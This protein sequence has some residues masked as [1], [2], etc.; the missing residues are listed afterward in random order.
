MARALALATVC[1]LAAGLSSAAAQGLF[2]APPANAPAD[3]AAPATPPAASQPTDSAAA[4]PVQPGS[5][6]AVGKPFY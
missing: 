2:G 1:L 6:T 5:P 4:A 3:N